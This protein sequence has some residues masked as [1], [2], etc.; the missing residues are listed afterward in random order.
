MI[1]RG[2]TQVIPKTTPHRTAHTYTRQVPM[3]WQEPNDEQ[4]VILAITRLR[5]TNTDDYRGPVIFNPGVS[6]ENGIHPTSHRNSHM[7]RARED[8][9]YLP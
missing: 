9:G 2:S 5:A 3:D 4:R 8:P 6:T 1:V 7:S